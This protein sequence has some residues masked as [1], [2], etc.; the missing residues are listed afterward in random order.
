M[1]VSDL[2]KHIGQFYS[3]IYNITRKYGTL[4][5]IAARYFR[6]P[7]VQQ[8]RGLAVNIQPTS[9]S[10]SMRSSTVPEDQ[11]SWASWT[12]H[13]SSIEPS[14]LSTVQD[15]FPAVSSSLPAIF[16]KNS[17]WKAATFL[18]TAARF[19]SNQGYFLPSSSSVRSRTKSSNRGGSTQWSGQNKQSATSSNGLPSNSTVP[20]NTI[21]PTNPNSQQRIPVQISWMANR[22]LHVTAGLPLIPLAFAQTSMLSSSSLSPPLQSSPTKLTVNNQIQTSSGSIPSQ[23]VAPRSSQSNQL[24][25][26]PGPI[27]PSQTVTPRL[28]E[29]IINL[30]RYINSVLQSQ[31]PTLH[32]RL[33]SIP[34]LPFN[35]IAAA[36]LTPNLAKA[37]QL[38]VSTLAVPSITGH[39]VYSSGIVSGPP[40]NMSEIVS[41]YAEA[42]VSQARSQLINRNFSKPTP[43][44]QLPAL[45]PQIRTSSSQISTNNLPTAL[46]LL[47]TLEPVE[48][49]VS[50]QTAAQHQTLPRLSEW[51]AQ[52]SEFGE[53][54]DT[55]AMDELRTKISKILSEELR[56]YLPGE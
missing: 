1:R 26:S 15:S 42:E 37:S 3:Q 32:S 48:D 28:S 36:R 12:T 4:N 20:T 24:Q 47:P 34:L 52:N 19:D 38:T 55:I 16:Q 30:P 29:R 43:R 8:P 25:T 54:D 9:A 22:L 27:I 56:R 49:Q 53:A 18:P 44:T 33:Q 6:A 46:N 2:T 21:E 17:M 7:R 11:Q 10:S 50:Y 31:I 39:G 14:Q 13:L 45:Q 41:A 23:P 40:H 5:Q 51:E 35:K